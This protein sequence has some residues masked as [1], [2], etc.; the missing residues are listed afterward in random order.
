M[1]VGEDAGEDVWWNYKHVRMV[2][3][4]AM[5]IWHPYQFIGEG[6]CQVICRGCWVGWR[7][8]QFGREGMK[9]IRLVG[10]QCGLVREF[11]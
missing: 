2:G 6:G 10:E 8:F 3:K 4:D 1:L 11:G 7:S 5:L 9:D